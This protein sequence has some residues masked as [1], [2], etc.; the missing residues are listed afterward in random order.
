MPPKIGGIM[1]CFTAIVLVLISVFTAGS[2]SAVVTV[3]PECNG[4]GA[5]F[6]VTVAVFNQYV[7]GDPTGYEI[8]LEQSWVGAC[9]TPTVV[10]TAPMPLPGFAQEETYVVNIPAPALAQAFLYTPRLKHPAGSLE[11]IPL[12]YGD[13]NSVGTVSC[14]TAPALRGYLRDSGNGYF[15]VEPCAA[16]CGSWLC[17]QLLDLTGVT[18]GDYLPFVGTNT[19]VDIVGDLVGAPMPGDPCLVATGVLPSPGGD[20]AVVREGVDSWGALKATYR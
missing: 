2:A 19:A 13:V 3:R 18:E 7:E 15:H 20:C 11:A 16:D 17:Y 5:S 8:V 9:E 1:R 10:E 4:G 12:R 14:Q 6:D